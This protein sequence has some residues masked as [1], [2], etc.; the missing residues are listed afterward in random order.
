MKSYIKLIKDYWPSILN[1]LL[2]NVFSGYGQTYFISLFVVYFQTDYS[3]GSTEF[4]SLYGFATLCGAFLIPFIGSKLDTR[5]PMH[6]SI[7]TCLGLGVSFLLLSFSGSLFGLFL[8]LLL[9]RLFGQGMMVIIANTS[10]AKNF[11]LNRGRALAIS[12]LGRSIGEAI[13]PLLYVILL[14]TMNWRTSWLLSFAFL[15]LVF[16]PAALY[17]YP[18]S[19][20]E[21]KESLAKTPNKIKLPQERTYREIVRSISFYTIIPLSVLPPFLLTGLLFHQAE[22]SKLKAWGSDQLIKAF[23]AFAVCRFIFGILAGELVDRFTAKKLYSTHCLPLALGI[24][25]LAYSEHPVASY[26]YLGLAGVC[27]GLASNIKNA[28]W[29]EM[30]GT[31]NLGNIRSNISLL[32]VLSTAISP[33]LFGFALDQGVSIKTPIYSAVGVILI[34]SFLAHFGISFQFEKEN[35]A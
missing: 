24:F 6:I 7:L 28:F 3:L 27:I 15:F 11:F 21:G 18:R 30:Y 26:L 17:L 12:G 2:H 33:V 29:P 4:G 23:L 20:G 35:R 34:S 22:I 31:E 14:Q 25:F 19:K 5:K 8:G 13:W 10:I 32:L 16:L 9:L 1:A